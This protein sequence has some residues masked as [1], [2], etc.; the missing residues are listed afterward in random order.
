[1]PEAQDRDIDP[2]RPRK[3]YPIKR[4]NAGTIPSPP[5]RPLQRPPQPVPKY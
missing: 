4:M 5:Q 1:M 3:K 2:E